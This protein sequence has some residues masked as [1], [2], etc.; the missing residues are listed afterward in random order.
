MSVKICRTVI[1]HME[2]KMIEYNHRSDQTTIDDAGD[3]TRILFVT[4]SHHRGKQM[5]I[6]A[7]LFITLF[8][9]S[10]KFK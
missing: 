1:S 9:S 7:V 4:S 2:K 3:S 10:V 6:H 8:L 5:A